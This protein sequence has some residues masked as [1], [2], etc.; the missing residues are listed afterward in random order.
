V[1]VKPAFRIISG[2]RAGVVFVP[3]GDVFV[4][5]RGADAG[6]RFDPDFDRVASGRHAE[7][8]E[9]GGAWHVRDLN[10]SNGTWVNGE[11]LGGQRALRDGD[12]V[13]FGPGGPRVEFRLVEDMSALPPRE[14]TT[15]RL[16]AA[17]GRERR[18]LLGATAALAMLV[19]VAASVAFARRAERNAL[20]RQRQA[21]ETRIDSLL[22]VGRSA[23]ATLQGEVGGLRAALRASEERLRELRTGLAAPR[24]EA[25]VPPPQL[26]A[27]LLAAASALRRQQLAASLDFDLIQ[28]RNRSAVAVIW[29]EYADGQRVTGTAFSVRRDGVLIT[30][31]HL[32]HG[33]EGV[34]RPRLIAV[35]FADSEQTFP[36]DIVA[37]S[38]D[39]DLAAVRVRNVIGGVPVV[40]G[41]NSRYDTLQAGTPVA[42]VGYPLA[43]LD[44]AAVNGSARPLISAGIL[45][46]AVARVLEV[47]GL[48]GAGGSGSPILDAHGETVGVLLGGRMEAGVQYLLAVPAPA[49]AALLERL[50]PPAVRD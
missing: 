38:A 25:K 10:S 41:L 48:G 22:A 33:S 42:L 14:T 20:D 23:E 4:A 29:V 28:A 8:I 35:R 17:Y 31:R 26:E 39:A 18:W 27:E 21:L 5:G 19:M 7:F 40:H 34:Q 49:V 30:T 13:T 2:R 16:R 47:Q 24:R 6:L 11:R 15:Q 3:P 44:G 45:T 36:A 12:T 43:A 37:V 32:V 46:A 50:P 1:P 9:F